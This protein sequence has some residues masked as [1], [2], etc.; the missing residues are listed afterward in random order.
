MKLAYLITAAFAAV[1]TTAAAAD[2]PTKA[3]LMP[4]PPPFNWTGFYIGP[5]AGAGWENFNIVEMV[6]G[7]SFGSNARGAIIGGGQVGFNYQVSPF[8]V[9]GLEGFIDTVASNNNNSLNLISPILGPLT[10]TANA[11][12]V[13]T[14]AGRIGFTGPGFDHW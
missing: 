3:P 1:T 8:F 2:L 11:D 14:L 12:W 5:N 9:I 6:S 10:A 7:V 4:V 13:G